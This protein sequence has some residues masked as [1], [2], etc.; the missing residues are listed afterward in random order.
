MRCVLPSIVLAL[1]A[2]APV[3]PSPVG[4][5]GVVADAGRRVEELTGCLRVTATLRLVEPVS[6]APELSAELVRVWSRPMSRFCVT[7]DPS[8]IQITVELSA[9][10]QAFIRRPRPGDPFRLAG[11]GFDRVRWTDT[12][13]RAVTPT[14]RSVTMDVRDNTIHFAASLSVEAPGGQRQSGEVT[15]TI[16]PE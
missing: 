4:D 3:D 5:G 10:I 13:P 7:A 1:A 16:T 8:A 2:C 11:A 15:A 6:S 12:E 14:I 9:G